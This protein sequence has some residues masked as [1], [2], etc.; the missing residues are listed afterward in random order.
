MMIILANVH[1]GQGWPLWKKCVTVGTGFEVSHAQAMPSV[2]HSLLLL[3]ACPDVELSVPSAFY[4]SSFQQ[5]GNLQN[6]AESTTDPTSLDL[7]MENMR[8]KD[9][10]L[11]EMNRENEVL[12]IKVQLVDTRKQLASMVYIGYGALTHIHKPTVFKHMANMLEYCTN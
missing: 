10:Q 11:L 5:S 8:R 3:P 7:L 12:K 6:G 4:D 2:A 9:Q 1:R